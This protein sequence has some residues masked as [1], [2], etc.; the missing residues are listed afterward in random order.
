[1][2]GKSPPDG[3]GHRKHQHDG[4]ESPCS[5]RTVS[6]SDVA[7]NTFIGLRVLNATA[8]LSYAE[9]TDVRDWNFDRVYKRELFDLKRDLFQL[10][11]LYDA[12]A[13]GVQAQLHEALRKELTCAGRTCGST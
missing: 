8:S 9:Y 6:H 7:N 3:L 13:P 2:R 11:N 12:T 5:D 4:S 10:E 1:M